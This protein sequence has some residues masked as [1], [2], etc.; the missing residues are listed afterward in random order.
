MNKDEQ[1]EDRVGFI[2]GEIGGVVFCCLLME[3]TSLNTLR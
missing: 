1:R 2:A 3:I